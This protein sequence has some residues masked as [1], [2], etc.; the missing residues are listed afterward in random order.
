MKVSVLIFLSLTLI[1]C[2]F[3][4]LF[5][6]FWLHPGH[7]EVPGQGSN[8]SHPML[9]LQQC[10]ILNPLHHMRNSTLTLVLS[11]KANL[12]FFFCLFAISWAAPEAYGG[13]QARGLIGAAAA[14]LRQSHS[15]TGSQPSLRPT[16][17]LTATL[18]P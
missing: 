16:P 6:V 5:G 11:H 13:S 9:Q 3:C 2:C 8:L 14:G 4:L 12:N 18:D 10:W 7:M 15:N 1:C 17:Q